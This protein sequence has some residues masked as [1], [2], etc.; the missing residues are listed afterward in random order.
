MIYLDTHCVIY[1]GRDLPEKSDKD[2]SYYPGTKKLYEPE[3]PARGVPQS[4]RWR[5]GLVCARMQT[6][7]WVIARRLLLWE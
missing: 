5:V 6:F 3:M 1:L 2:R 4:P 7:L